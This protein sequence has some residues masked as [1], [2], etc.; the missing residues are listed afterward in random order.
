MA[1]DKWYV[2]TSRSSRAFRSAFSC[3][4]DSS[5][6][7]VRSAICASSFCCVSYSLST[8]REAS[9]EMAMADMNGAA[10]PAAIRLNPPTAVVAALIARSCAAANCSNAA[11]ISPM[12]FLASSGELRPTPCVSLTHSCSPT[13][14]SVASLA[15]RAS[16]DPK[17]AA[18]A[19]TASRPAE[20]NSFWNMPIT[21]PASEPTAFPMLCPSG[22]PNANPMVPPIS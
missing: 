17:V 15:C 10:N 21:G 19:F 18:N 20:P 8:L 11:S 4:A 9:S 3:V 2:T 14:P 5:P 16:K 22:P 12:T 1:C 6:F 7:A 13:A